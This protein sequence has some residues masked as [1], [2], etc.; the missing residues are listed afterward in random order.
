MGRGG[1]EPGWQSVRV[2]DFDVLGEDAGAGEG[3]EGKVVEG[4]LLEVGEGWR[5]GGDEPILS[6][7]VELGER[8][9]DGGELIV[10]RGTR[11]R[12]GVRRKKIHN[13]VTPGWRL[14]RV[15]G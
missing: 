7:W 5:G 11:A 15:P 1:R 9:P 10:A 8:R 6:E 2:G 3:D 14:L 4:E 13:S 12:G